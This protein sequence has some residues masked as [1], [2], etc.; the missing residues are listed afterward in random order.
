MQTLTQGIAALF[1]KNQVTWLKGRATLKTDRQVTV[2]DSN[3]TETARLAAEYIVI[4]TSSVPTTIQS[5]PID[6]VS[7]PV[8]Y[9][10]MIRDRLGRRH[11]AR[12]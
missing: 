10:S 11:R 6:Q 12:A 9:L 5:A 1:K 8:G 4:A 7:Y 2:L 3:G